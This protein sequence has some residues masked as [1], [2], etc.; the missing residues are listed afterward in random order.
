MPKNVFLLKQTKNGALNEYRR[1]IYL[2]D[3][4]VIEFQKGITWISVTWTLNSE[5]KP[6]IQFIKIEQC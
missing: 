5:K 6:F 1:Q 3:F 2:S 4:Q